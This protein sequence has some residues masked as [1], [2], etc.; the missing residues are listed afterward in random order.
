MGAFVVLGLVAGSLLVATV[1]FFGIDSLTVFSWGFSTS[2]E[3][4]WVG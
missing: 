3:S 2:G 1:G 4:M